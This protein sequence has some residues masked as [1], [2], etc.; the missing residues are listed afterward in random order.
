MFKFTQV[1]V[2]ISLSSTTFSSFSI[3]IM[4]FFSQSLFFV[5]AARRR[6]KSVEYSHLDLIVSQASISMIFNALKSLVLMKKLFR[7]TTYFNVE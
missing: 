1:I 7:K 6:N 2:R 4:T 3:V 5:T